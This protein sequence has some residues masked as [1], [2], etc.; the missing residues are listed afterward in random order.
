M[1]PEQYLE[2]STAVPAELDE[3][4]RGALRYAMTR[5]G[6][7]RAI[8]YRFFVAG[9]AETWHGRRWTD[10]DGGLL[11]A[12][13]ATDPDTIWVRADLT[14]REARH[15]TLHEAVHIKEVQMPESG[16]AQEWEAAA[17]RFA[18]THLPLLERSIR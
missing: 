14:P 5:L 13:W 17:E 16:L 3:A 1:A 15:T 9:E 11:G 10:S 2:I 18:D 6:L 12:V 7:G 4:V 8:R